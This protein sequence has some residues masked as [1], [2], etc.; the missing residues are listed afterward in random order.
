MP[1]EKIL[2][3]CVDSVESALAAKEGGASRLELCGSLIIGGVT[4]GVPLLRAVKRETG[5]PVH[6]LLRPRFGDFLYT[7]REYSLMLEDAAALLEAGADALVSGYLLP[8]GDLDL[9]R[10]EKLV[11]LAHGAGKRFTLHRAFDVCRDPFRALRDCEALGV[12]TVLTSGQAASCREGVPLLQ[13]LC[14]RAEKTEIL[15]GAG[16]DA[17]AVREIGTAIPKARSF[18]M[19]GKTV[20]ESAMVY[21]REG[22][23]MG[24]PGI[25]EFQLWRTDAEKVRAAGKELDRL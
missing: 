20:L 12:D 17:A 8:E 7:E 11:A 9:P 4:P 14:A 19:S 18:H 5:L 10:L 1:A 3:V 6:T 2:E 24:L 13:E 23:P 15:I 16:V 21:R 22:V 25:G